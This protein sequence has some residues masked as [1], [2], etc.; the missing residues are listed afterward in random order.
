MA[1]AGAPPPEP[2][3]LEEALA[4][5]GPFAGQVG[6]GA[7]AGA[8]RRVLAASLALTRAAQATLRGAQSGRSVRAALRAA[9]PAQP[10]AFSG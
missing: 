2:S 1:P 4:S 6:V 10:A 9:A 5:A 8:C 3:L 7:L